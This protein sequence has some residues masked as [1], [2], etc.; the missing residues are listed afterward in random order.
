MKK[1]IF[2][3]IV[4]SFIACEKEKPTS[5]EEVFYE[6]E[7]LR[8]DGFD[9]II[10]LNYV[11]PIE[12]PFNIR[13]LDNL[14][15]IVGENRIYD[16]RDIYSITSS[17]NGRIYLNL[18]NPEDYPVPVYIWLTDNSVG[19]IAISYFG[20]DRENVPIDTLYYGQRDLIFGVCVDDAYRGTPP[21]DPAFGFIFSL[22]AKV[23]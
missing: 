10:N 17:S 1:L 12:A 20:I 14:S 3:I 23:P 22:I 5:P 7:W 11:I 6:L 8:Y 4:S 18:E 15:N 2:L 21:D 9:E 13:I 16:A 19:L